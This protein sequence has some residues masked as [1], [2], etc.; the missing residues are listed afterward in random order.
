M[1][2]S[3]QPSAQGPA[4]SKKSRKRVSPTRRAASPPRRIR[5]SQRARQTDAPPNRRTETITA[6]S[7]ARRSVSAA[8]VS[9]K[10]IGGSVNRSSNIWMDL[11][12]KALLTGLLLLQCGYLAVGLAAMSQSRFD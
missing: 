11:A 12:E 9:E 2:H 8:V 7:K 10:K 3:S 1:I 5:R 4:A 6:C